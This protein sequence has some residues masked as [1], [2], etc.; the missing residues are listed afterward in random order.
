MLENKK[1]QIIGWWVMIYT[2]RI[3]EIITIMFSLTS[4]GKFNIQ[5]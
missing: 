3:L 4:F 1:F 2:K 5:F